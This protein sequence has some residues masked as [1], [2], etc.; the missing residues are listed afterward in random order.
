MLAA[1]PARQMLVFASPFTGT[2]MYSLER[3]QK[4]RLGTQFKEYIIW[5]S[6]NFRRQLFRPHDISL[7]SLPLAAVHPTL[8]RGIPAAVTARA[9]TNSKRYLVSFIG[10]LRTNILVRQVVYE[11]L[12]NRTADGVLVVDSVNDAGV[13]KELKQAYGDDFYNRVMALSCF[14]LVLRGDRPRSFRYTEAVCS[15]GVPV[16]VD[17]VDKPAD[18]WEVP[19]AQ[20]LQPDAYSVSFT[21]SEV[22]AIV[23]KLQRITDEQYAALQHNALRLCH[24]HMSSV[25][26]VVDTTLA[27]AMASAPAARS[28]ERAKDAAAALLRAS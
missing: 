20:A 6:L 2:H 5:A 23:R 26:R 7:P 4:S 24:N 17:D 9:T 25:D 21:L 1:A 13:M 14:S 27:I 15:G 28:V 16:F 8:A 11:N 19:F 18:L 10:T 22:D 12:H 3:L